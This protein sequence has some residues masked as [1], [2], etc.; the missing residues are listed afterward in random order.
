M[1]LG[2]LGPQDRL[3][4]AKAYWVP[5]FGRRIVGLLLSVQSHLASAVLGAHQIGTRWSKGVRKQHSGGVLT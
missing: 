1:T 5:T 2:H 4:V 3:C